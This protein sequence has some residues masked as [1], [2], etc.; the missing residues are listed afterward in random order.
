MDA[1]KAANVFLVEDSSDDEYFIRRAMERLFPHIQIRTATNGEDALEE[2]LADEKE[3]PDLVLMDV[4]LPRVTGLEVLRALRADARYRQTP[5]VILTSSS[6]RGD[7]EM[8]YA[9]GA[10]G[11]VSKPV[12]FDAYVEKFAGLL[13]YWLGINR[14]R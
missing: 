3:P 4:R 1:P 10:N 5:L 13:H 2:L 6:H 14:T 7:I 9:L 8:A 12:E 11:Y